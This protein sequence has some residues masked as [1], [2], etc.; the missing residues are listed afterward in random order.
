MIVT[1]QNPAQSPPTAPCACGCS[2]VIFGLNSRSE[3]LPEFLNMRTRRLGRNVVWHVVVACLLVSLA[4]RAQSPQTMADQF[5]T[6][7]RLKKPGWWPTKGTAAKDDY[8]GAA[9]CARCH[10][11]IATSQK[12][13]HMA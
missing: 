8:V 4:A 2:R 9:T 6:A 1:P 10:Y 5:S 11:D 3:F 7:E 13:T 12:T